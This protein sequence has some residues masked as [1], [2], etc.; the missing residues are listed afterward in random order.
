[1]RAKKYKHGELTEDQIDLFEKRYKIIG[2]MRIVLMTVYLG[3]IF[4]QKPSWCISIENNSDREKVENEKV[5][6]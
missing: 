2:I 6:K 3:L 1:M 5:I 4:F